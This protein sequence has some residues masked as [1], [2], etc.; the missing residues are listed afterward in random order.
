M[1]DEIDPTAGITCVAC[2]LKTEY[3]MTIGENL[4]VP[5]CK[6][7]TVCADH[8]K[9]A[10]PFP[11]PWPVSEAS[12][13]RIAFDACPN[14][15]TNACKCCKKRRAQGEVTLR[16]MRVFDQRKLT[17]DE[18]NRIR[19][20]FASEERARIIAWLKT[21]AARLVVVAGGCAPT[22]AGV[23]CEAIANTLEA[24]EVL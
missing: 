13:Q 20:K 9:G 16:T 22:K 5:V 19:A 3:V 18:E 6:R 11:H 23:T 10:G 15:K 12:V 14:G 24:G 7:S 17:I 2:G 4:T 1:S 21:P 8:A